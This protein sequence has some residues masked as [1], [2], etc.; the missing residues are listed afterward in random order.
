MLPVFCLRLAAGMLACLF[1][2]APGSAAGPKP[3][4]N[5]RYFRTHLLTALG[6]ATVALLFVRDTAPWPVLLAVGAGAT[7]AFLGSVAWSLEGAPAGRA[8]LALT[9]VCLGAGL[10]LLESTSAPAGGEESAAVALPLLLVGDATAAALLG[11]ALSAM[12]LG[13]L[14]LISPTMSLAPLFRLLGALAVALGLRVAADGYA[15]GCWTAR[16]PLGTLTGDVALWLPLRWAL[17]LLAPAAM[18]VMA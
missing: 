10:V 18:V 14:Y 3:L 17:G 8:L 15:L 13:H 4:V 12:L 16:H 5:P 7:L 11:A 6:L 9:A 2:L 1:L